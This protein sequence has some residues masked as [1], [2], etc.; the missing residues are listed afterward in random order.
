MRI[1]GNTT[2][3]LNS[4]FKRLTSDL[5]QVSI[6]LGNIKECFKT[7]KTMEEIMAK[8]HNMSMNHLI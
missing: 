8:Q 2:E 5:N 6:T 4:N 3:R 1:Y 7:L